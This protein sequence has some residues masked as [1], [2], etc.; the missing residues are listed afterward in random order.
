MAELLETMEDFGSITLTNMLKS[1]VTAITPYF[2]IILFFLWLLFSAAS[3]FAILKTTG[4]K[5]FWHSLTAMSFITFILSLYIAAMNEAAFTFLDGYWVGFYIL[6][7]LV[8][9]FMLKQYK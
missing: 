5:R 1:N 9:L 6:M 2:S 4:K 8:S 7:S 3:Y